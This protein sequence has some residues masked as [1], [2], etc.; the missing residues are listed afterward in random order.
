MKRYVIALATACAAASFATPAEA[1]STCL[2][3]VVATT[4]TV[5]HVGQCASTPGTVICHTQD[6]TRPPMFVTVTICVPDL[7]AP[8]PA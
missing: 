8:P 5:V 6:T 7:P 2:I 4:S 3:V 1:G